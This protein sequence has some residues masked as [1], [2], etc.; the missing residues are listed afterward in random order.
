MNFFDFLPLIA[1]LSDSEKEELYHRI[2]DDYGVRCVN[3]RH[4]D[5]EGNTIHAGSVLAHPDGNTFTVSHQDGEWCANYEDGSRSRLVLQVGDRGRAVLKNSGVATKTE[6][7]CGCEITT[8]KYIF[9]KKG[10]F[11]KE[12]KSG[13]DGDWKAIKAD[14]IPA[15]MMGAWENYKSSSIETT[16][17]F[18]GLQDDAPKEIPIMEG[19]QA[20]LDDMLEGI[21]QK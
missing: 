20:Q 15:E 16:D 6:L 17:R 4:K 2:M 9:S 10:V 11:M 18:L 5:Y 13:E 12:G 8:P 1:Q 19:T 21:I 7:C 14:E 3:A